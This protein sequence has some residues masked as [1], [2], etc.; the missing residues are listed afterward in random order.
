MIPIL[1]QLSAFDRGVVSR[2]AVVGG[3]VALGVYTPSPAWTI[4][5]SFLAEASVAE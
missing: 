5:E 1:A 3:A 4:F 2:Q